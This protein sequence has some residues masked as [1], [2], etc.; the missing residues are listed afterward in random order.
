MSTPVTPPAR[1]PWSLVV[2]VKG[3]PSAK[4]RLAVADPHRP[5]LA[6]AFASDTLAVAAAVLGGRPGSRL[7]V[8][9]ADAPLVAEVAPDA[10]VVPDPGSGL[11]DAVLAGLAACPAESR[12]G[13]LLGDLPALTTSDL[14]AAL[15]AAAGHARAFVPDHDGTGTVL[16]TAAGGVR[17]E[18]RFGAG[19]AAAHEALGHVRLGPA[20]PGL[21]TDVDDLGSLEAAIALGVG[22]WTRAALAGDE[23]A[24]GS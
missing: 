13:V 23:P 3:T 21:R 12:R 6:R 7:V 14:D 17:L 5:R 20:L 1:E 24:A 10:L 9:T 15:D 16:L 18:P 8:V 2:P 19:S 22:P 11:G 4:S